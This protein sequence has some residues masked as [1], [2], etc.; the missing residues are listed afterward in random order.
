MA[1]YYPENA[2]MQSSF[3]SIPDWSVVYEL[4]DPEVN[5][6]AVA[7]TVRTLA[8]YRFG[9]NELP[10]L[11]NHTD[12]SE[13]SLTD[14]AVIWHGYRYGVP[15][16]AGPRDR[17]QGFE[18]IEYFQDRDYTWRTGLQKG[19][20]LGNDAERSI[21]EAIPFLQCYMERCD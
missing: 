14:A 11:S 9:S 16:P 4:T 17:G 10:L 19:I 18:D 13:W 1:T 2:K 8:D 21:R 15:Q 12:L 3:K 20:F 7:A 5:I 6:E